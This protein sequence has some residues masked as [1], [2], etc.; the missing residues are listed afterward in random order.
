MNA[1]NK[2]LCLLLLIPAFL[3]VSSSPAKPP[4]T[5]LPLATVNEEPILAGDLERHLG[6]LHQSIEQMDRAGFDTD[7]LMFKLIN[8]VLIGQ[9]ARAAGMAEESEIAESLA[10]YRDELIL[11]HLEKVEIQD[12]VEP[13]PE[14]IQRL[15]REQYSEM[16]LRIVTANEKAEADTILVELRDGADMEA[17]A[18]AR[19]VDHVSGRGG[20]MR[21][22]PRIKLPRSVAEVAA[23]LDVGDLGGPVQTDLG[24]TVFRV[25]AKTDS[26]PARFEALKGSLR[27]ML[28]GEKARAL[29]AELARTAG[30]HH[31]VVL[32]QEW[33]ATMKPVRQ[34]DGRM[35]ADTA[36]PDHVV[37][38]VGEHRTVR[39]G[40]YARALG[41]RWKGVR[42]E[43][44]AA[45][46]APIIL[47]ALLEQELL[48][49]EGTRRGY[50]ELPAILALLRTRETQL[51]VPRYL[52]E[53]VAANI[54]VT[55]EEMR[56]Y[57]EE[58][59][60]RFLRPPRIRL[61]QVTVATMEEAQKI[62]GMLRGGADLAWVVEQHST[63]GYKEKGGLRDW[64]VARPGADALHDR[65]LE[66]DAGDVLDPFGADGSFM[67]LKMVAREEQ[68][69]F[70]FD[71]ISGNIRQSVYTEK[72][73]AALDRYIKTLR[74]RSEI[75]VY[76]DRIQALRIT[77]AVA[78]P[79]EGEGAP[80]G[81]GH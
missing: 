44:A 69:P 77:G 47:S 18:T 23:G 59:K 10:G 34:P 26:D 61:G 22:A 67:V 62:A 55:P 7:R 11:K 1:M 80:G 64:M 70:E 12:H 46:A 66:I 42:T 60:S 17:L 8:D 75:V 78:E 28:R 38:R 51:L 39:A 48:T 4:A 40:D 45:A 35:T 21:P 43:E 41:K 32:D 74:E 20:L 63:D 2:T 37:A 31:E 57:Y 49:A 14:E 76:D 25:E 33:I 71:R 68:G 72:A 81:H 24:W 9:E 3:P 58:N 13:T 36:E 65:L 52:E 29:R 27:S 16:Q 56:S 53:V 6:R 79:A 54:E 30:E 19:S 50:G 5:E 15:F 73:R